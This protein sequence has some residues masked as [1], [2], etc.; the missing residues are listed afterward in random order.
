MWM[1]MFRSTGTTAA[2]LREATDRY[3]EEDLPRLESCDGLLGLALGEDRERGSI[4]SVGFWTDEKSMMNAE[5]LSTEA[6][7]RALPALDASEPIVVD[8]YEL[9]YAQGFTAGWSPRL[10]LM[11]F[12]GLTYGT[13]NR[14]DETCRADAAEHVPSLE[15]IEGVAIARNRGNDSLVVASFWH[16]EA[17]VRQA[18]RLIQQV[19]DHAASAAKARRRP[20]VD[21]LEV[22]VKS[23]VHRLT[24]LQVDPVKA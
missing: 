19:S 11:R 22:I 8:H 20:H 1:R 23:D 6:R 16:S 10:V 14:A 17:D 3:R 21:S 12:G 4:V 13:L 7:H 9:T 18:E 2:R 5:R 15:G 24:E